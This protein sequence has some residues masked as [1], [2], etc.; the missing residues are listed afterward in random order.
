MAFWKRK[1]V[2]RIPGVQRMDGHEMAN[3]LERHPTVLYRYRGNTLGFILLGIMALALAAIAIYVRFDAPAL[4]LWHW[5]IIGSLAALAVA[6]ATV[7]GYWMHYT[8]VHYLAV[9]DLHLM[10]GNGSQVTAI[11][12]GRLDEKSLDFI[13]SIEG[14][15]QGLLTLAVDDKEFEVRIFSRYAVLDN[16]HAFMSTILTR[17]AGESSD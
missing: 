16:L 12:W 9:S 15:N 10:I 4:N 7:V 14:E 13:T 8:R 17:I 5:V 11:E 2:K 1:E 3:Y 6:L